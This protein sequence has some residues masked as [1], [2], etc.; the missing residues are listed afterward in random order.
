MER[1]KVRREEFFRRKR[2][3]FQRNGSQQIAPAVNMRLAA[4]HKNCS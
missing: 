4:A 1:E 3:F 2:K